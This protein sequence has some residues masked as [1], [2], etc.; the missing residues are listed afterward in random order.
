MSEYSADL[1]TDAGVIASVQSVFSDDDE[2]ALKIARQPLAEARYPRAEIWARSH[3]IGTV[4]L[5]R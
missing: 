3:H 4:E 1:V 5:E 2:G